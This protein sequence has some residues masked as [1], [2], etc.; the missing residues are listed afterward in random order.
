MSILNTHL[1]TALVALALSPLSPTLISSVARAEATKST[2]Q[3]LSPEDGL[4]DVEFKHLEINAK[5]QYV[6]VTR[7]QVYVGSTIDGSLR[8]IYDNRRTGFVLVEDDRQYVDDHW[9][10]LTFERIGTRMALNDN[11]DFVILSNSNIWV[12]N[13]AGDSLRNAFE[14]DNHQFYAVGL[15]QAGQY[16][17]VSNRTL[18]G[19]NVSDAAARVLASDVPGTFGTVTI[20]A[21]SGNWYVEDGETHMALNEAGQYVAA[22]SRALFVGNVV[23][24]EAE[25]LY[26]EARVGFRHVAIDSSGRYV[27]VSVKNVFGGTVSP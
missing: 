21:S 14:G 4:G 17:A 26:E 25:K 3:R 27:A 22:S 10:A 24:G 8:K 23:G 2:F 18:F 6:A 5:G 7:S 12:G 15:N 11:G 19:G 1:A 9:Y 13:V 16:L 20:Q